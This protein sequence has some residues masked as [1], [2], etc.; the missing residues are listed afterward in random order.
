ME[1]YS[2]QEKDKKNQ[3]SKKHDKKTKKKVSEN[4]LEE[5]K[6]EDLNERDEILKEI[7]NTIMMMIKIEMISQKKNQKIRNQNIKRKRK[8]KIK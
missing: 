6:K 4:I 3:K 7:N 5:I 8:M 2:N 1:N